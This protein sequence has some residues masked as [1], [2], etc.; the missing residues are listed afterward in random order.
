M[1][2]FLMPLRQAALNS[3]V[4]LLALPLGIGNVVLLVKNTLA[5]CKKIV[6]LRQKLQQLVGVHKRI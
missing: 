2:L 6:N 3:N 1:S 5:Y 4:M